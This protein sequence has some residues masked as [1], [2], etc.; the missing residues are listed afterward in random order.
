MKNETNYFRGREARGHDQPRE[1]Q[2]GRFSPAGRV[3][4]FRGWDDEDRLR[5]EASPAA[6]RESSETLARL[7]KFAETL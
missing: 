6:L 3:Q 4:W 5:R 1:L 7:R 2:D